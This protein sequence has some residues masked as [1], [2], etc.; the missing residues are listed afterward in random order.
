MQFKT[1]A[2]VCNTVRARRLRI[3]GRGSVRPAQLGAHVELFLERAWIATAFI[4][5][6]VANLGVLSGLVC[7][8]GFSVPYSLT[9]AGCAAYFFGTMI[10]F[11]RP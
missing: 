2:G 3:D 11:G 9:V 6:V 10:Y 8:F 4:A 7:L 5:L 1:A